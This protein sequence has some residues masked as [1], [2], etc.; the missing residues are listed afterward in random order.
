MFLVKD[1]TALQ[2]RGAHSAPQGWWGGKEGRGGGDRRNVWSCGCSSWFNLI[3]PLKYF[4]VTP[5]VKYNLERLNDIS[6]L[7]SWAGFA[8]VA[9]CSVHFVVDFWNYG[10]RM[11]ESK[12]QCVCVCGVRDAYLDCGVA[13]LSGRAEVRERERGRRKNERG[14][15]KKMERREGRW[16]ISQK[17]SVKTSAKVRNRFYVKVSARDM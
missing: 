14:T 6:G 11:C 17:L 10:L 13:P 4:Q 5:V 7:K 3:A 1:G 8:Q 16:R 9:H 12:V 15:K 2:S